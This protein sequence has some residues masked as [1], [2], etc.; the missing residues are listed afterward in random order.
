MRKGFFIVALLL[1]VVLSACT[2][3]PATQPTASAPTA[4]MQ[5]VTLNVFAAAS[6]TE[7]FSKLGAQFEAEHPGVTVVFNFAGSQQLAQQLA[8]GAPADVFAS[9]N[10]KQMDAVIASGRIANDQALPF[11]TNQLV[12][13]LPKDNPAKLAALSDLAKPGLKLVLAAAEVPVGQYALDFLDK[14]TQD[15]TLGAAFKEAVLKNVVSYEANVKAVLT[16]VVLGEA[17][18][19][20]VY[21]SDVS[22]DSAAAVQQVAIPAALNVVASY[23]IGTVQNSTNPDSA[24]AFVA[25][26]LSPAGQAM[27]AEFGFTPL[28]Q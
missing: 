25:Y 24:A 21:G 18:A 3:P 13:I 26:L 20:I 4:T 12:V 6:L 19:G 11:V 17:D 23:P 22:G 16:K 15:A 5:P 9:A 28:E 7:A 27:L 1:I 8:D 14:A 10:Q 2:A